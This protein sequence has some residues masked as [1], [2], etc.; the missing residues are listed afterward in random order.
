MSERV[1]LYTGSFDPLTNGH[2]D[3]LRNAAAIFDRNAALA[4]AARLGALTSMV[5]DIAVSGS[6]PRLR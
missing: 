1:A 2:I 6:F 4:G 3:V 5:T